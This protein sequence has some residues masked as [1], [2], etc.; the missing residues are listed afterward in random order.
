M[1]DEQKAIGHAVIYMSSTWLALKKAFSAINTAPWVKPL[2]LALGSRLGL[3]V[4]ILVFV[5]L[6]PGEP[7]AKPDFWKALSVWDGDWYLR[8]A[9]EGYQW[10]GPQVQSAVVFWPLY[11]L[12]G[13]M[14]GIIFGDLNWGFLI[15]TTIS[16]CA[17]IYYLYRLAVLDFSEEIAE[18]AIVYAAIFPGA[19]VLGGFYTEATAFALTVAAFYYARRGRWPLAIGLGFLTGLTRLPALAILLP[20]AYEYWRQRGIR[21]QAISLAIVPMGAALF[22]LY[23]WYLSGSPW[24]LFSAEQTAWFRSSIAPWE[25]VRIA[26]DRALWPP[27]HYIVSV[28]ILDAA[29]IVLFIGLT[30]WILV[31]MPAAYWL[32]ALP[33]L[34]GALSI[35]MNPD[36]APPTSSVTRFLMAIFPGYIALGQIAKNVF[37]DQCIRWTF[38]FL[39]AVFA[40]Y[41]FSQYWVL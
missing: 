13:K 35:T 9:R 2:S 6:F 26:I 22:G 20:L 40:I 41:F 10:Q 7:D 30:L 38:A 37:V 15:V 29:S 36:K 3:Y 14:A 27:T 17:F 5:G 11:P 39:L 24:T 8:I 12:L 25:Q 31:K 1:A 33:V 28:N 23:I 18:R 34:I 21:W 16:F 32:Y 19:F 4:L